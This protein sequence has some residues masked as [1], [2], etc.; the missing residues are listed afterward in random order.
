MNSPSFL[1]FKIKIVAIV[2]EWGESFCWIFCVQKFFKISKKKMV[3]VCEISYVGS[4]NKK[5]TQTTTKTK[6]KFLFITASY[7]LVANLLMET[8]LPNVA[9]LA[10]FLQ[11]DTDNLYSVPNFST[12]EQKK[13]R[14]SVWQ[15][16]GL[17]LLLYC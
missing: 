11:H 6:K 5:V 14:F 3:F 2:R 8:E 4:L 1:L 12:S 10:F 13:F 7:F 16:F 17:W 15:S 9:F